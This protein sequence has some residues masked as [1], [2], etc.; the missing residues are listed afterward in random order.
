MKK[1]YINLSPSWGR[2]G[3][4]GDDETTAAGRGA[5]RPRKTRSRQLTAND[6]EYALAA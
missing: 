5:A 6:R 2:P 3:F 4:D 1:H